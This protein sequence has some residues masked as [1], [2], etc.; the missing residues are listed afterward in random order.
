MK[1]GELERERERE[2]EREK[3]NFERYDSRRYIIDYLESKRERERKGVKELRKEET[4]LKLD[5]RGRGES[6]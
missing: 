3:C 2:R 1:K 5:E 4:E 6:W